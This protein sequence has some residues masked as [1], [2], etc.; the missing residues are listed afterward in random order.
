MGT[1]VVVL[2]EPTTGQDLRGVARIEGLVDQLAAEG[3][4]VIAISHDMRFVAEHFDRIVVLEAGRVVVDGEPA[5]AFA[6]DRWPTLRSTWLEPP[7]AAV[8][9][10]RLGLESTPTDER[11]VAALVARGPRSRPGS[12][13]VSSEPDERG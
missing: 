7:L 4:T 3:R 8:V 11:L 6:A 13:G 2:D 5:V 1:P 12:G 10:A 9:G